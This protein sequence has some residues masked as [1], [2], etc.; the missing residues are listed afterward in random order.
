LGYQHSSS[1]I[2]FFKRYTGQT[3]VQIRNN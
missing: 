2:E 1:F 3:P